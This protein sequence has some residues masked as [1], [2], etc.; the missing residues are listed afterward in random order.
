MSVQIILDSLDKELGSIIK[1]KYGSIYY[2]AYLLVKHSR[3]AGY[4]VGSRGSV[5]SSLVATFMKIT[6]VNSLAPHYVC[7]H[8]KFSAFKY[9]KEEL[10]KYT[11]S[12]EEQELQEF[13]QDYDSGLDLPK[14]KCPICGEEMEG[15][16]VNIPFETFLGFKGDKVPDIDLNFS[17]EYQAKAHA[18]CREI[19]GVENTFRGGT[20]GTIAKRTAENYIKDYYVKRNKV[21]R[22]CEVE[23]MTENIMGIKRQTGQHPG[24][25]VVVPEGIDINEVTPVQFP[26]DDVTSDWKT[27]HIDYHKFE[28]NLLKLD[29]LGHDDPTMMRYLMN[30]VEEHP[31]EF[32]FTKVE[33][34]P[35]NDENV[36]KMFQGI[37]VLGVTYEQVLSKVGSTGL[38]EFGTNLTKDMCYEIQPSNIS[39]L[40]RISGLSHGTMV[41]NGNE[42]EYFLGK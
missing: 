40:I 3:D 18:F 2:I 21:L 22:N 10:E 28:A 19:F 1:Y 27:T 8:C 24:G 16:G 15:D 11:L 9:T 38:P 30:F 20:I 41:W 32:P 31:E 14:K 23:N 25:I 39:D 35:L 13:L 34:I 33:D 6:E 17:G 4:V 37:D 42:R 36:L 12:K 5:G 29:I 7:P 26:A